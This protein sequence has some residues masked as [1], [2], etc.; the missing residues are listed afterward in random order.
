MYIDV[1]L[2]LAGFI[3]VLLVIFSVYKAL[4]KKLN[5]LTEEFEIFEDLTKQ[6][7]ESTSGNPPQ[8]P[9]QSQG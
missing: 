6:N 4:D 8:P 9:L 3:S 1:F 5:V 7:E 2:Y